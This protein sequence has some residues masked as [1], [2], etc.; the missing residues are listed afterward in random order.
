MRKWTAILLCAALAA[1]CFSGCGSSQSTGQNTAQTDAAAQTA[2][3]ST[4]DTDGELFSDGDL[5]DVS[6]QTPDATVTLCGG[7]GTISDTTRGSS[8]STVTITSKGVYRVTGSSE[9]VC[10]VINDEQES[11]NVCLV[12]DNVRMENDGGA[13]IYV[14]AADKVVLQ[15][16][17]ENSIICTAASASDGI[18]GVIYAKDDL[19]INGSGS[20]TVTSAQYGVVCK[21]DLKLTGGTLT[22]EAASIG[23]QA[24]DSL[25]IADA[26][27][28]VEAGHDGVQVENGDGDS[29]FYMSGG[30]LTVSA[31]YDAIDVG[32]SGGKSACSL[33]VAGGTLTLTAGGG[34]GNSKN[35][36]V[37]QKGLKCEGDILLTGGTLT[38]SA[39]D[40]AIHAEGSVSLTD[41]ALT[42]SSSDDGVHAD[43]A[44]SISGGTLTVEKSYEGLEAETVQ[45]SG[46]EI[47]VF[48]SDDGVNAAGGSDTGSTE[49]GPWS[50]GSGSGT[51]SISGGRLYVNAEGDGLDSNG[52]ISISGGLTIVEGPTNGGNG[53]LDKGD[54]AA[55]TASIT[56][57]TVLALGSTGMAINFDSGSQCSALV[58]ISASAGDTVTVDDG[59][60][61]TFTASKSFQ[62]A[63]YSSPSLQQGSS[64]T[65]SAG[66]STAT[67]DFGSSQFYST[68]AGMGPG[69]GPGGRR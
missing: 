69:M 66:G 3:V 42:L 41:G 60:G 39:A 23:I 22:V 68:V 65:I 37:S 58:A 2:A 21:D 6:G 50:Q 18:D 59:S 35:S 8:G 36:S 64:Y 38:V 52:S 32:S 53:A 27:V 55:C 9:N 54:T 62:C 63:V 56:G 13:C 33:T 5:K 12:L 67:M 16:V 7:E 14:A 30:T 10:I 11:G 25:R 48:A 24:N 17:G 28:K 51:L 4:A 46:G 45:I 49:A 34:S 29:W 1:L 44:L 15:C 31:G 57:G 26:A 19:T 40:D 47:S 61:F 43:D 20:L